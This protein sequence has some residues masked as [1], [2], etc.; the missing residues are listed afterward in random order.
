MDNDHSSSS[1]DATGIQNVGTQHGTSL[2]GITNR[3]SNIV[4]FSHNISIRLDE[5]NFLL[6][7]QQ[8]L[9]AIYGYGLEN[10]LTANNIPAKFK[11]AQDEESGV[12]NSEFT[13]W[14]RQDHLLMSWVLASMSEGMLTRMVG[15]ECA[16]EIWER[17]RIHFASQTRAKIKQLK[18][19]L[20]S[21][22]KGLAKMNEY[23]LKVKNVVDS[24]AAVGNPIPVNDYIEVIFDGLSDEYDSVVTTVI[25]RTEDYTIDEIEALL[26]A[27]EG[28][29][30]KKLQL[31]I[32]DTNKI[33]VAS[34]VT[35]N[36]ALTQ[37]GSRASNLPFANNRGRN[38]RGFNP[39]GGRRGG[40][41]FQNSQG[42][43]FNQYSQNIAG[44]NK[45][46][47]ICQLC[48][49][50]G[51]AVWSC[52]H[53]FDYNFQPQQFQN[54]QTGPS[55]TKPQVSAMVASANSTYDPSWYVDSG[56]S[57]HITPGAQNLLPKTDYSGP[58]VVQVGNGAGL[59]IKSIGHSF[60]NFPKTPYSQ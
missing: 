26:L 13:D 46:K 1:S 15:C 34:S 39:R 16:F 17:V 5:N 59:Q 55:N 37:G 19:Q 20:R 48:G 21:M 40:R 6:W 29:L 3:A 42:Y 8:V 35:A 60:I 53:R 12:L 49:K 56:A 57:S 50:S 4:S 2:L 58:E 14:R 54:T 18:T 9:T 36:V 51:H 32:L 52:Y 27:Q 47:I 45:Q 10:H 43:Q 7:K 31:Q 30:E 22:R 24:L 33:E 23:L 44:T 28:R 41:N 25:S 11:N 38:Q